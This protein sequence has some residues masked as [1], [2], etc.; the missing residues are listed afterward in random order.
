[1]KSVLPFFFLSIAFSIAFPRTLLAGELHDGIQIVKDQ[2]QNVIMTAPC[3]LMPKATAHLSNLGAVIR[4]GNECSVNLNQ[5][6]PQQMI[7]LHD[8]YANHSGPNC[9]NTSLFMAGVL[10]YRRAVSGEE[11]DFLTRSLICRQLTMNEKPHFGDLIAIHSR[12]EPPEFHGFT[13]INDL[14]S[15]SKAGFDTQWGYEI[16]SSNYVFTTFALGPDVSKP[17]CRHVHGVPSEAEC[18]VYAQYFR[19]HTRAEF[20]E[21]STFISKNDF[22]MFDQSTREIEKIISDATVAGAPW[23]AILSADIKNKIDDA[24][25][26]ADLMLAKIPHLN[27]PEFFFWQ[28]S[29]LK[30]DSFEIQMFYLDNN[31]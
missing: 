18:P 8:T 29:R 3:D 27:D 26:I 2:N 14:I 21:H 4:N 20:L 7:Q 15:F 22:L 13:Y 16:V 10:E 11:M 23:T 19:C 25:K 5:A 30:L 28:S 9:W 6:L 31:N 12:G 17:K 24:K 1:M